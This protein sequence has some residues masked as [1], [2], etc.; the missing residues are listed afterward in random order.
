MVKG[1]N[2]TLSALITEGNAARSELINNGQEL[3]IR[4]EQISQSCWTG[5]QAASF[6]HVCREEQG[7]RALVTY[8]PK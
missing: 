1:M 3:R 2:S 8:F 5:A 4:S 6:D 7:S